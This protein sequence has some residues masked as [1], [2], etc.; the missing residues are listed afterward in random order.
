VLFVVNKKSICIRV[1]Y[2]FNQ[3]R[4]ESAVLIN[5]H[6][7]QESETHLR[8]IDQSITSVE[9]LNETL[10]SIGFDVSG[11]VVAALQNL[12]KPF[13][14]YAKMPIPLRRVQNGEF[15]GFI[16]GSIIYDL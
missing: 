8:K 5:Q 14:D 9:L 4:K 7:K 6:K 10:K 16:T 15:V 11:V 13:K 3:K 2:M 1:F 12:S